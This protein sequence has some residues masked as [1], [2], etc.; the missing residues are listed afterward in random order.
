MIADAGSSSVT[1]TWAGYCH[2][3]A[4]NANFKADITDS[5][6]SF[7][8]NISSFNSGSYL[9]NI[10][11]ADSSNWGNIDIKKISQ[12]NDGTTKNGDYQ[13]T[14]ATESVEQNLMVKDNNMSL[15]SHHIK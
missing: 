2:S 12:S 8:Q 1:G 14:G 7:Y 10:R 15:K 3:G 9:T 6:V 4:Y 13:L 11:P 5:N